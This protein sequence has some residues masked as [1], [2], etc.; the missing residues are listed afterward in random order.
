MIKRG[1]IFGILLVGIISLAWGKEI[2]FQ[3]VKEGKISPQEYF[4]YLLE[5]VKELKEA[6]EKGMLKRIL[7]D[8]SV[9]ELEKLLE[10]NLKGKIK[11][12]KFLDQVVKGAGEMFLTE[13]KEEPTFSII[14]P[15]HEYLV[16]QKTPYLII[17]YPRSLIFLKK[18]RDLKNILLHELQHIKD[19]FE[20]VKLNGYH[21][22]GEDFQRGE[23]RVE[24]WKSLLEL[25]AYHLELLKTIA[26]FKKQK[27]GKEFY[28]GKIGENYT[29]YY[30]QL[31]QVAQTPLEKEIAGLQIKNFSD[32]IP[33]FRAGGYRLVINL[34]EFKGI[35]DITPEPS[36]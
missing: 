20:G 26:L 19:F 17:V 24:F 9:K 5:N 34:S 4:D 12:Q 30:Y 23:M 22:K 6:K 21:I 29:F 36:Q 35:L 32:I 2:T 16:G 7:F 8:P 10:E 31:F 25:R 27:A 33:L 15:S 18:E 13:K 1:I 11:N 28:I 14:L 3:E